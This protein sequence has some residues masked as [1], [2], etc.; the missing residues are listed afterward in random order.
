MDMEKI[1]ERE[2]QIRVRGETFCVPFGTCAGEV[3]KKIPSPDGTPIVLL[4]EDG[5]LQEFNHPLIRDAVLEPVT[6]HSSIG[7]DAYKRSLNLLFFKA[8]NDLF[9]ENQD[10]ASIVLH[11]SVDNALY[12]TVEGR[13]EAD[14]TLAEKLLLRM[15]ALAEQNLPIT[16]HT[17][18]T[19]Y[20]REIFLQ[21]GMPDKEK[22]FRFRRASSVNLYE[23]DGYFDYFYGYML[24]NTSYLRYFDLQ[25]YAGGLVLILPDRHHPTEVH[26]FKPSVKLFTVQ[27][28]SEKW[29]EKRGVSTVGDLNTVLSQGGM[30][31]DLL[32]EEAR[33]EAHIA[34]I[35]ERIASSAAVKFVMIAGPS[36]SGKT[37]F[38]RRLSV[39][40]TA[41]GIT[42]HPISLDNYYLDREK[43]PVD[44]NGN[45]D[46]ESLG[47][48]DVPLIRMQMAELLAGKKVELPHFNFVTGKPEYR[49]DMLQLG[50]HDLLVIE[51]IHGLSPDLFVNLPQESIFRIYISALTQLNIDAHN[52]VSTTDGRLIRRILRDYRTRGTSARETIAMWPSVRNGEEKYIFPY[53]EQADV[54]FNSALLYE[55]S[56]L[57]IYVEPLLFQIPENVPEYLEAKRLLK[58]LNYFLGMASEDVPK[59][60]ILREFI[61]GSCFDV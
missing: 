60:S 12:Y 13:R 22:L 29:A 5:V 20:A 10:E 11:F 15:R 50:E 19:R 17:M 7:F 42:P 61:G 8:A 16:K 25:T 39:Q 44:E 57:K 48:L 34:E 52:R 9:V 46:L 24:D 38:S 51:G 58:F 47:A 4:T 41:H 3:M 18:R 59:N 33:Q 49:G 1:K 23:L 28:Q 54:M 36:S 37:T 55:L 32:V 56:V 53:Q 14:V 21:E 45:V 2:L 43:C 30:P 31:Q 6:L 26:P 27:E 40:L 35:A